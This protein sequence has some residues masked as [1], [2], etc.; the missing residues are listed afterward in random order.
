MT[1]TETFGA[2][3]IMLARNRGTPCRHQVGSLTQ[4]SN[5]YLIDPRKFTLSAVLRY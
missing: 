1:S 5:Y 3:G 4:G 2:T